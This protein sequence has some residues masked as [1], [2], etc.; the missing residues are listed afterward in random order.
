MTTTAGESAMAAALLRGVTVTALLCANDL[1]ALG[2]IRSLTRAGIRVPD[3]VTVIGY[4]DIEFAANAAVPLTSI[5]Q[6]KYELGFAAARLVISECESPASHAHQRI[7]FQPQLI[8]RASSA[9]VP[10]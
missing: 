3:D 2:A 6:P 7:Q 10:A 8:A 5:R 9:R 1:L 4:D